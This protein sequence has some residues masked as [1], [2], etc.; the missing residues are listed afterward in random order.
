[1]PNEGKIK[2]ILRESVTPGKHVSEQQLTEIVGKIIERD[3]IT[4]GQIQNFANE[5]IGDRDAITVRAVDLSDINIE[6]EN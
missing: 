1:M 4:E 2:R 3:Q 5:V 6:L